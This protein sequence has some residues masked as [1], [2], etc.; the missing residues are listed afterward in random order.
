MVA[1]EVTVDEG[2]D[3]LADSID[4]QLKDGR[5]RLMTRDLECLFPRMTGRR[6]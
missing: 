3:K 4:Q 5:S 2:L 1:K 6:S